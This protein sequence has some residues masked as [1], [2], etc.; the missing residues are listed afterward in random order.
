MPRVCI[1]EGCGVRLV[2]K[3]G[4]PDFRRRFCSREH[5]NADKLERIQLFRANARGQ[6]CPKCGRRSTGD[7][8]FRRGVLRH[9]P[10]PGDVLR[11]VELSA[12]PD[13]QTAPNAPV[14]EVAS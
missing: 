5:K 14:R 2:K 3:N 12:K 10:L 11:R 9:T 7:H 1:R 6:K 4:R 8:R 13:I